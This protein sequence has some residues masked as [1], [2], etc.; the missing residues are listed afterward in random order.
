MSSVPAPSVGGSAS[1]EPRRRA[2]RVPFT[3]EVNVESEHNFWT[4]FTQNLSEGGLFVATEREVPMGSIVQF[5][6]RLPG[7]DRVWLVV[8]CVRWARGADAATEDAP[9][10]IGLQFVDV[11]PEL[12]AL[13]ET[14]IQRSRDSLF[15]D[16]DAS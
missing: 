16:D 13:I 2:F 7:S 5:E 6:M 4:G 11:E 10:G 14:F 9:V 8:G 12:A 1:A 15:F 3:V